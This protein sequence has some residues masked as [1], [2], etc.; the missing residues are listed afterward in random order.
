MKNLGLSKWINNPIANRTQIDT[1]RFLKMPTSKLKSRFTD[2]QDEFSD[3]MG[4]RTRQLMSHYSGL[5]NDIGD[6]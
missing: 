6:A 2:S 5:L 1:L 3:L 4:K